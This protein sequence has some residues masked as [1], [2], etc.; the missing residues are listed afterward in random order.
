MNTRISRTAAILASVLLATAG[1]AQA[2]GPGDA[3]AVSSTDG[4]YFDKDSNPTFKIAK[5]GSV[6]WYTYS[7]YVRYTANCMQCHGP[8][9]LGSSY[10]PSLVEAA[11]ALG[12]AD[13]LS[14]VANGKQDINAAQ[15]LAMPAFGTNRNVMCYIDPIYVYLRAR[16][17]GAV[18]RGRPHKHAAK[19]AAFAEAEDACM[20]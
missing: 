10:A 16:S 4:E 9:G 7:G 12:Y 1:I 8:D 18:G 6:D 5:D 13:F 3:A 15:Q 11:K 2:S 17:D 19:P 14:V 20:D